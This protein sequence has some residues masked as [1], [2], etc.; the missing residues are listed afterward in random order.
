M[1][2]SARLNYRDKAGKWQLLAF[3]CRPGVGG[4]GPEWR[5]AMYDGDYPHGDIGTLPSVAASTPNRQRLDIRLQWRSHQRAEP[6]TKIQSVSVLT[7]HT[8]AP[9]CSSP[10][11]LILVAAGL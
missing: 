2:T 9:A 11:P 10:W 5:L 8:R 6:L 3:I 4:A 1:V 7:E